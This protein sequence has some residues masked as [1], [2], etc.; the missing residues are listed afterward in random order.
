MSIENSQ[1]ILKYFIYLNSSLYIARNSEP[2]PL[3]K[4]DEILP[5]ALFL[6]VGKCMEMIV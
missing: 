1:A 4:R 2:L 6:F 5:C 3:A